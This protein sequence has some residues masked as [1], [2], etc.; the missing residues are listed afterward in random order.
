MEN[1][2]END[3]K[4]SLLYSWWVIIPMIFIFFPIAPFLIYRRYSLGKKTLSSSTASEVVGWIL[5]LV[6]CTGVLAESSRKSLD[7][8]GM[9]AAIIFLAGGIAL[10]IWSIKLKKQSLKYKTYENL[11]VDQNVSSIS[12]IASAV[13]LDYDEVKKDLQTMINKNHFT[14][15]YINESSGEI[16]LPKPITNLT[17]LQSSSEKIS[18]VCKSCGAN[19]TVIAGRF[20]ECEYCGSPLN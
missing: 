11:I 19:N 20:S 10:I 4:I 9:T 17:N 6:G 15:A 18:I 3:Q 12:N 1:R 8:A 7:S 5:V 13:S 2:L 16:L 14:D